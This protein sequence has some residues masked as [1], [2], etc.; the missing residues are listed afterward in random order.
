[1]GWQT[2][3]TE[4]K[5]EEPRLVTDDPSDIWAVHLVTRLDEAEHSNGDV[6]LE[7]MGTTPTHWRKIP[8]D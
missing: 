2:I 1:M 8:M 6:I 3:D 7:H 5:T 4:P